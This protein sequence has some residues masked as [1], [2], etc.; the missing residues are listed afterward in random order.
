MLVISRKSGESFYIGDEIEV[1]VLDIAN[2]KIK[3]GINAPGDFKIVRK[4]LKETQ[5]ANLDSANSSGI[6]QIENF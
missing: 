1:I 4:E 3:V 6:L 5:R 2:S